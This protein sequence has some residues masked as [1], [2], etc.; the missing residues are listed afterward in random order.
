LPFLSRAEL[1]DKTSL[2]IRIVIKD[3]I[4]TASLIILN[5]MHR[6]KYIMAYNNNQSTESAE[7]VW[8]SECQKGEGCEIIN[9]LFLYSATNAN[10]SV[11]TVVNW[12]KD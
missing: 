8:V 2:N 12:L 3:N 7:F 5:M 11:L 10:T 4:R 6:K 9:Q 1:S